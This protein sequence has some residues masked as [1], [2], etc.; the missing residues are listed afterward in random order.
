[1]SLLTYHKP[2]HDKIEKLIKE[3]VNQCRRNIAWDGENKQVTQDIINI[4]KKIT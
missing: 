1:M 2:T 4:F 3:H